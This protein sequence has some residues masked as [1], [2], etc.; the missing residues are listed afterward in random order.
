MI[1]HQRIKEI[2]VTVVHNNIEYQHIENFDLHFCEG[3]Q[4]VGKRQNKQSIT[5]GKID[6]NDI[7]NNKFYILK[8]TS[9]ITAAV[10]RQS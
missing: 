1:I 3:Q 6:V 4:R 2:K 10:F 5:V 9:C 7:V 8:Q